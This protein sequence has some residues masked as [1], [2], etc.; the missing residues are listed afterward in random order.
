MRLSD[1]LKVII[2]YI[3][4]FQKVVKQVRDRT[5]VA[6]HFNHIKS[7]DIDFSLVWFVISYVDLWVCMWTEGPHTNTQTKKQ[8]KYSVILKLL[9][10]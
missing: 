6:H 2:L 1:S 3:C 5:G 7:I 9:R 4:H 8:K 10:N